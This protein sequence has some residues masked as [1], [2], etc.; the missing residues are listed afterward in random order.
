VGTF[1]EQDAH[2]AAP[3]ALLTLRACWWAIRQIRREHG[4]AAGVARQLGTTWNTVCSS[5]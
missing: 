5:T 3:R 4:S 1:T 2:I